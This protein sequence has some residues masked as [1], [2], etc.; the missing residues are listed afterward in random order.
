MAPSST[1]VTRVCQVE[2]ECGESVSF[3]SCLHS[4]MRKYGVVQATPDMEAFEVA[5]T[6]RHSDQSRRHQPQGT[7]V[8]VQVAHAKFASEVVGS[9]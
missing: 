5:C 1:R 4:V 6:N 8:R 7:P 3:R 9:Y 2:L